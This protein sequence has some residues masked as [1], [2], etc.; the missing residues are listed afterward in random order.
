MG[1]L[2]PTPAYL[3]RPE[4]L[5][6]LYK[7]VVRLV[8]WKIPMRT[9]QQL[10]DGQVVV[11][12]GEL[13]KVLSVIHQAGTAKFSGM[14]RATLV[15]LKTA[16]EHEMRWD[17]GERIE[18][19][20]LDR[21]KMQYLYADENSVLFMHPETFEQ[22]SLPRAGLEKALPFL[23]EGELIQVECLDAT[24][25]SL[26]LPKSHPVVVAACAP[27]IRGQGENIWKDATLENG[28]VILVPQFIEPG[29]TILVEIAT[30]KYLDRVKKE[31]KRTY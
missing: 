1:L 8:A 15:H 12:N 2:L 16:R 7:Q 29:D 10:K 4:R 26:D 14:I 23:K 6:L 17:P 21:V 9:A 18:D 5:Y 24:P 3:E 11:L 13:Y 31:T 22:V 30:C 28:L 19:V 20:H 27:G 25:V